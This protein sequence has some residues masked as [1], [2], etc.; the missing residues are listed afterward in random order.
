[1]SSR[2]R[3]VSVQESHAKPWHSDTIKTPRIDLFYQMTDRDANHR[4]AARGRPLVLGVGGHH[5]G[6]SSPGGNGRQRP[7]RGGCLAAM[8]PTEGTH[9]TKWLKC[10]Q[11]IKCPR[12][13]AESRLQRPA[14]CCGELHD[15][16]KFGEDALRLGRGIFPHG[17]GNEPTEVVGIANWKASPCILY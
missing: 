10:V 4:I 2:F 16:L 14:N 6:G 5:R 15:D 8:G 7:C 12:H 11:F 3:A 17:R 13:V 1:M 9:P